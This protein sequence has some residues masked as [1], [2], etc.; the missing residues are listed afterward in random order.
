MKKIYITTLQ[1]TKYK[2]TTWS[3]KKQHKKMYHKCN[4]QKHTRIKKKKTT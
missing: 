2:H 1:T 4:T 3:N